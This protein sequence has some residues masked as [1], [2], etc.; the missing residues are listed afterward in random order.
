MGFLKFVQSKVFIEVKLF[1][2]K[3]KQTDKG[4]T[5]PNNFFIEQKNIL[6]ILNS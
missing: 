3:I 5:M 1:L 4:S 6:Q 2:A